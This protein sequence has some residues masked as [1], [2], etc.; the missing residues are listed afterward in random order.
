MSIPVVPTVSAADITLS[1]AYNG[2]VVT[3]E[4]TDQPIIPEDLPDGF[5]CTIINYSLYTYSS[6]TLST[7][8]F[9]LP[10]M[11]HDAGATSFSLEPSQSCVLTAAVV[12]DSLF[13]FVE[14]G[15]A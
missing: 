11:P 5:T 3:T 12:G 15:S 1:A 2:L 14:K 9:L 10:G 8:M 4:W 6:N 7:A 13:Y